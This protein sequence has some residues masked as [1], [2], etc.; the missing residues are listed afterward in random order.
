MPSCDGHQFDSYIHH[1]VLAN[2]T[3]FPGRQKPSQ[4]RSVS[5]ACRGLRT[6]FRSFSR[7]PAREIARQ[8]PPAKFRHPDHEMER[9]KQRLS[10]FRSAGGAAAVLTW[11][12][13]RKAAHK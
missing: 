5:E 7:L 3:R 13:G 4:F 10:A 6:E 1:A 9:P 11:M 2:R 12:L 8:S